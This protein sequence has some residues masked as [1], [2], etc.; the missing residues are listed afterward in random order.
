M[1]VIL[2]VLRNRAARPLLM[3]AVVIVTII[4]VDPRRG[5]LFSTPTLFSITQS[6][7][8][9]G[10]VAL[11]LGMTMIIREFDLSVGGMFSCAGC[12]AV[13]T[14][15]D[16]AWIGLLCGVGTGAIGGAVQ[17][18]LITRLRLASVAVTLGG[19]LTLQGV[20]Y[21]LT[22]GRSIPFPNLDVALAVNNPL[23]GTLSL[24]GVVTIGVFLIAALVMAYTRPG[25][26][27]LATGGDRRAAMIA[28]VNTDRIVVAVFAFSGAAAALGGVL[29]SYGLDAA[30]P[31]GLADVLVPGA[32]AAIIGGVSL[33]G[34]TGSPTGIALG[35]LVLA[36][37]QTG[38]N[39]IGGAHNLHDIITGA[40][41]LFIATLDAP[42]LFRMA[43]AWR[44]AHADRRM[45]RASFG[46]EVV[47]EMTKTPVDG[48]R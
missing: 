39:A 40:I 4:V 10:L 9:L 7:A 45:G 15:G 32:A 41:L 12:I 42:N 20:S 30:S 24:R 2:A 22:A 17:G 47:T 18:F 5:L 1:T 6:F 25:V 16:N 44:A 48:Q 11:G 29:L 26:E 23:L 14:G 46:G 31:I 33:A 36:T 37:L 27:V 38:L 13:L 3:L 8:T 19:L 43:L 35:V 21:V 34:G 28:G